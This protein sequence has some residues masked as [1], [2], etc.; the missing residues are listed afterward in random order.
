MSRLPTRSTRTDPLVPYTKLFRSG[1]DLADPARTYSRLGETDPARI[2]A[3]VDQLDGVMIHNNC[4]NSDFARFDALLTQVEQTYGDILKRLKWVR[5]EEHTSE[6]QSLM[7]ISYSVFCLKKK[8]K[9]QNY[10]N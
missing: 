3:V 8:K 5:S 10:H 2:L 1:F 7:R 6:L 4:E 9:V